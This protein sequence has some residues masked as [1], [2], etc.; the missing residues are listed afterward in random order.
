MNRKNISTQ[1]SRWI[2][3]SRRNDINNW[4]YF[5]PEPGRH[6]QDRMCPIGQCQ[7]CSVSRAGR[8]P[9]YQELQNCAQPTRNRGKRPEM[10]ERQSLATL[11]SDTESLRVF[12]SSTVIHILTRYYQTSHIVVKH[13]TIA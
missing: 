4:R 3:Y 11:C 10:L 9:L 13:P 12:L 2:N 5:S 1:I 6:R 8:E 7:H